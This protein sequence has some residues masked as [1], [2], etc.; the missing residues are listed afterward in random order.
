MSY[1]NLLSLK[2]ATSRERSGSADPPFLRVADNLIGPTS[3]FN[4]AGFR[5]SK[6][7]NN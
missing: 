5:T 7:C 1:F 6:H 4:T 3:S 2:T